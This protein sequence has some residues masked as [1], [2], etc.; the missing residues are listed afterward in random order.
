[1]LSPEAD[2]AKTPMAVEYTLVIKPTFA[3]NFSLITPGKSTLQIAIPSQTNNVS[4]NKR[5]I[6]EME[7]TEIP[8]N[9]RIRPNNNIRSF[10]YRLPSFGAA[11]DMSAKAI[12]GKLV[13]NPALQFDSPISFRIIPISG[14]T[15][16]IA[17][18]RLNATMTIPATSRNRYS[19]FESSL[20]IV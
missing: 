15:D 10:E 16:V 1:M 14:P 8:I 19:F 7:R 9:S 17:G 2:A 5:T 18:R 3:G 4:I 13:S 11:G 6:T 20:T 12:S